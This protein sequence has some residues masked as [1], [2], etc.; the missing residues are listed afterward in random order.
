MVE[1]DRGQLNQKLI[2]NFSGDVGQP[3]IA[4]LK[5]V[6][7]FFVVQTEKMK[8][9]RVKI[10][11]VNRVLYDVPADLVCFANHLAAFDP[12]AGHP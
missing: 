6:G 3:E 9:G 12:A 4:S 10:V 2:H 1:I 8:D 5:T 11:E 7:Q